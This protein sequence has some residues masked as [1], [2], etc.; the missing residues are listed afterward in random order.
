MI[1]IRN[2]QLS[3]TAYPQ[4]GGNLARLNWKGLE[5]LR[6]PATPELLAENA[7]LYGL[8]VLFPPNRIADGRFT[9][10]GRN[11]QLPM[12]EGRPRNNHLHGLVLRQRWD[13]AEHG[14]DCLIMDY[15]YDEQHDAFAG[16]PYPFQL[17]L[18]YHLDEDCLRQE[19]VVHNSGELP[20][21]YAL[22]FHS[23]FNAPKRLRL[24]TAPWRWEILLPRHLPSGRR[25]PW[26]DFDP[27]EWLNPSLGRISVH[28]PVADDQLAGKPFRGALLDYG[29]RCFAYEID[30]KF[31]QWFLWTPEPNSGFICPEPM[32]CIVNA[33]NLP[34]PQKVTGFAELAVGA[35][36]SYRSSIR[37]VSDY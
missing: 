32:S 35:K 7:E 26:G 11:C 19:L 12:N 28:M 36:V 22:G 34:L 23:A 31:Q 9:W 6:T 27:N 18:S 25:L 1:S 15:H 37:E 16:F 3:A 13:L 21:P 10:R 8:P 4:Y 14:E 29:E 17:R 24:S 30:E 5:L 20:L 2:G 33:P